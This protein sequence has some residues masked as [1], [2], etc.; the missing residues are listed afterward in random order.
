VPLFNKL[1]TYVTGNIPIPGTDMTLDIK[2]A[3]AVVSKKD[4][5]LGLPL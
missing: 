4:D 1:L 3:G 5:Y 2:F